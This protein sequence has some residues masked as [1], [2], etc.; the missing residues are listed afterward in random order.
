MHNGVYSERQ[1]ALDDGY[2]CNS[3]WYL[4]VRPVESVLFNVRL[5]LG[6]E[7]YFTRALL[8]CHMTRCP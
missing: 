6:R 2:S 4:S 8:V 5:K 1:V 7:F 3:M